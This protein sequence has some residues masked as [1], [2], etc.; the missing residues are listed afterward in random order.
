MHQVRSR[1]VAQ[2]SRVA[3]S[4]FEEI[5]LCTDTFS[6]VSRKGLQTRDS[7]GKIFKLL[8]SPRF[9]SVLCESSIRQFQRCTVVT[10]VKEFLAWVVHVFG[11]FL[12]DFV[13]YH[14]KTSITV[15]G[16]HQGIE[17][18]VL[19][20]LLPEIKVLL[21]HIPGVKVDRPRKT[22]ITIGFNKPCVIVC[23]NHE[24]NPEYVK[25]PLAFAKLLSCR[26][27]DQHCNLFDVWVQDSFNIMRPCL[28]MI[29]EMVLHH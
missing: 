12:F 28:V 3:A 23:I 15:T 17:L 4:L 20:H 26:L 10:V 7:V 14:F 8:K 11:G 16:T 1:H 5:Y 22:R 9:T 21:N 19:M 29:P 24:I 2:Q 13:K 6:L 27:E 25:R 18:G